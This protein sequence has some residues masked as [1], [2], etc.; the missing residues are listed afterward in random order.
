MGL[1]EAK[2]SLRLKIWITS[3]SKKSIQKY[4][5]T[6]FLQVPHKSSYRDGGPLTGRGGIRNIVL[7]HVTLLGAVDT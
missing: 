6:N 2:A 7:W 1:R 3:G 4:R 5:Q